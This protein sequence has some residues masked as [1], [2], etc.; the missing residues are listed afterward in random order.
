MTPRELK[1]KW[2]NHIYPEVKGKGR[3]KS[4]AQRSAFMMGYE[5]AMLDVKCK[6]QLLI[7]EEENGKDDVSV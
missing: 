6:F 2:V 5:R 4:L 3:N 7:E 1:L